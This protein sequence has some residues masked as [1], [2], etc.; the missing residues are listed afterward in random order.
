MDKP[1][2]RLNK[3]EVAERL[4]NQAI[5][6]FFE[7]GDPISVHTLAEA[8][9]QIFYDLRVQFGA[10]SLLRDSDLIRNEYKKEWLDYLQKYR[11]FFKHA[12]REPSETLEFKESL[13][14]YHL[15]DAVNM[16]SQMK[17]VWTPETVMLISWITLKYPHIMKEDSEMVRNAKEFQKGSIPVSIDHLGFYAQAIRALRDGSTTNPNISLKFGLPEKG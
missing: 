16:Y 17:K 12:D 1:A 8:A 10:K 13:N 14:H 11:N 7:E 9:S 6:L 5:L 15:L 4:L 2:I 3:F